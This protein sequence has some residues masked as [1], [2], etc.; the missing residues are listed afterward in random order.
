VAQ[1]IIGKAIKKTFAQYFPDPAEQKKSDK[2]MYQPVLDWFADGNT[3]EIRDTMSQ[4]DYEKEL[5][6]IQG[7]ASLVDSNS[8]L[9]EKND[10]FV[11]M[12]FVVEALHQHSMVGKEDLDHARSYSDMLGSMLGSIDDLEDFDDLDE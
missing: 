6:S 7:L 8:L 11:M 9:D 12:D 3:L 2:N 1:H 10:R 4:G 5:Q